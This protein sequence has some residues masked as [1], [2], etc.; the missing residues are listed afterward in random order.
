MPVKSIAMPCS[1]AAAITSS[2]RIEPPGWITA[3]M[4]ASASEAITEPYTSSSAWAALMAA[5]RAEL[6]RLIWPAPTPMVMR[7]RP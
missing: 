6:T 3:A 4:P 5:M 2:S 7:S 1:S